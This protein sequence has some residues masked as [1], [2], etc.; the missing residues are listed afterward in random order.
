[1]RHPPLSNRGWARSPTV[2]TGSLEACPSPRGGLA[3]TSWALLPPTLSPWSCWS[4]SGS[5]AVSSRLDPSRCPPT[6][7]PA[8]PAETQALPCQCLKQSGAPITLRVEANP[9]WPIP[10]SCAPN[11]PHLTCLSPVPQRV[12]LSP[13]PRPLPHRAPDFSRHS[14]PRRGSPHEL[15]RALATGWR[16]VPG[17]M[18]ISTLGSLGCFTDLLPQLFGA[19]RPSPPAQPAPKMACPA[20]FSTL[21]PTPEKARR[22]TCKP[23]G[24]DAP[25]GRDKASASA[26][27]LGRAAGVLAS[28]GCDFW[29]NR[30]SSCFQ[31]RFPYLPV[32]PG[33]AKATFP[34]QEPL[35]IPQ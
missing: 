31:S 22:K 30:L 20:P 9:S 25:S 8:V 26:S 12:K 7:R 3:L 34:L 15:S 28:S 33:S 11:S 2:G 10:P 23:A 29:R 14:G 13:L 19:S 24:C 21:F 32:G 6:V 17:F 4:P 35:G 27:L 18:A 16:L 1:M 5:A